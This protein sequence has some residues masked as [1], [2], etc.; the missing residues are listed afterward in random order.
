MPICN[1]RAPIGISAKRSF[2]HIE[3]SIIL[4]VIT[5]LSRWRHTR[6]ASRN[7]MVDYLTIAV[8]LITV[9]KLAHDH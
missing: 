3:S 1:S 4:R 9:D 5:Y 6:T 2:A 7:S 8:Y